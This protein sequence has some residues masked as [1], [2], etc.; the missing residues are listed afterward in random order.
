MQM[1]IRYQSGLRVEAILLAAD[2]ERIRVVIKGQRDAAE[3]RR[4]EA[5]WLSED[6]ES[7]EIEALIPIS[8]ADFSRFCEVL[9]PR[10]N[11]AGGGFSVV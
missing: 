4:G 11:A 6:G 5:G 1:L 10:V 3:L 2:T 7:I 8:E 9:R